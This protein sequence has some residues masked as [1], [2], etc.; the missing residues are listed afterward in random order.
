MS[1]WVRRPL[2]SAQT[3]W[4]E[5]PTVNRAAERACDPGPA[6]SRPHRLALTAEMKRPQSLT[7]WATWLPAS[8]GQGDPLPKTTGPGRWTDPY[9]PD[10]TGREPVCRWPLTTLGC[11]S[12]GEV[13]AHRGRPPSS[14]RR[15]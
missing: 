2:V 3:Q 4:G 8:E 10:P 1:A 5:E 6:G 15:A 14:A 13:T 7:T 11:S 12:P 9:S